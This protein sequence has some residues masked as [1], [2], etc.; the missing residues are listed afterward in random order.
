MRSILLLSPAWLLT[1]LVPLAFAAEPASPGDAALRIYFENET[2]ALEAASLSEIETADDWNRLVPEYRRQL[3]EMLGLDPLP[4]R[5]PLEA[6]VARTFAHEGFT[7]ENL[8]FQSSPGLYVTGNLYVPAGLTGPAPAILY[9]CGHAPVKA[10]GVSY[11]NKTAYQHH[12]IWFARHGYVCLVIDTLQLGEIEGLHHGLYRENQWWWL[13]RG[14]TPAGVEAWNCIRALDYLQSR[15]EVDGERIGVTGR[16]GG[17]AYSWWIAAID[18]RIRSAVPVAGITSLRNH[19]VDG[20][21]EGHCDCM[22]QFNLYR[23]DYPQVAAL[24]AP[25]PLLISN[26]DKDSIF[27]LDGVVD[28]HAK[29][30]RIYRLL[31][32]DKQLGLQITEGPHEDT[33][34]LHIH[35]FVWMNRFVKGQEA[36][37]EVAAAPLFEPEQ[38]RVFQELPADQINS[39]IQE[40]FVPQA[41][42]SVPSR[43]QWEGEC[44]TL[45]ERLRDKVFRG[46]PEGPTSIADLQLRETSRARS[47]RFE[48][49]HYE[50]ASQAAFR[51]PLTVLRPIS[52][53][54]EAGPGDLTLI[55]C[56]QP[57]WESTSAELA[58]LFPTRPADSEAASDAADDRIQAL[59]GEGV[60]ALAWFA[61]RGVGPT[62]WNRDD[63]RRTHIRRRF[64]LLGQTEDGMRVYDVRLAMQAARSLTDGARRRLRIEG[65]G[66]A[67]VWALYATLFEPPVRSLRATSLPADHA[68]GPMLFNVLRVTTLARSLATAAGRTRVTASFREASPETLEEL[69]SLRETLGDDVL[70]LDL[71]AGP[72]DVSDR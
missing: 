24:V 14:Y 22:Y 67:A 30:R 21:I 70:R 62:E 12:G 19:V 2:A 25:R 66:D 56:D 9:V 71:Q 60:G 32:A 28:V 26:T 20:C 3:R 18:E 57:R 7:V 65:D 50:L 15:P 64:G 53:E 54:G 42:L 63:R 31:D 23:W 46:W 29:V 34:E 44:Q 68:S 55:V 39:R 6:V 48:L 51:L 4:E 1:V 41:A 5:T 69:A 13:A 17:G 72:T 33:Q 38:L 36:P 47:G 59:L 49:V 61:P 40:R 45:L 10:N 27:P 16:S 37:I 11:G 35:S 52:S 8:H 58:A 43:G